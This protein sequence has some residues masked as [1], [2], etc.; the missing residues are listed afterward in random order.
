MSLVHSSLERLEQR[1]D[2]VRM[3]F[4]RNPVPVVTPDM[5]YPTS[6]IRV[7]PSERIYNDVQVYLKGGH[8]AYQTG[9]GGW[10]FDRKQ[11][12]SRAEGL[13][14]VLERM[15][16]ELDAQAIV[17]R[18]TSGTYMAAA[19]QVMSDLPLVMLRKRGEDSHGQELEG[20]DVCFHRY[21]ILDD[22]IGGGST[23]RCMQA[24]LK[25]AECVAIVLHQ[26]F[27][28]GY[29]PTRQSFGNYGAPVYE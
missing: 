16:R 20:R 10:K 29:Q 2:A 28:P 18:G 26:Y 11:I 15:L 7:S 17:V 1:N 25:D 13:M 3:N 23:V 27:C 22:L 21:I 9:Y 6:K 24:D 14:P 8:R 12:K 5:L 4:M 19:L